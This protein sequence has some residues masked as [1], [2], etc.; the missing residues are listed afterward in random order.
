MA[1]TKRINTS[2]G[3]TQRNLTVAQIENLNKQ[4]K[5]KLSQ[6]VRENNGRE[7]GITILE[8][9]SAEP[10]TPE[11]PE[12]KYDYVNP[13]HYVQEDGRQTWE[14]MLDLWT[15]EEV[16]IWCDIT[17][18]KYQDRIGKKPNEDINREKA[19]IDWYNDLA[20]ELRN[21]TQEKNW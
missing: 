4:L 17:V 3:S 13:S 1:S 18:F 10:S 2:V 14:R 5:D 9:D 16:A 8:G 6:Y 20:E 11:T 12:P 19:K 7:Y 21:K 15:K